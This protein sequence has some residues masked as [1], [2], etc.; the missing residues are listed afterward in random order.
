MPSGAAAL[1]LR[2]TPT[3]TRGNAIASSRFVTNGPRLRKRHLGP[4]LGHSQRS[5]IALWKALE[6]E[7]LLRHSD[8]K[9]S[10]LNWVKNG[11]KVKKTRNF[12]QIQ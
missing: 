8:S 1:V 10:I 6:P 3:L 7:N 12:H 9:D 2:L 4:L 5:I 11:R